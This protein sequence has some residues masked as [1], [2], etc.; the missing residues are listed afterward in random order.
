[1]RSWIAIITVIAILLFHS[2]GAAAS[3]IIIE[4]GAGD[5]AKVESAQSPSGFAFVGEYIDAPNLDIEYIS[6]D[7]N[8]QTVNFTFS[9]YGKFN[10]NVTY[11]M[12]GYYEN[13]QWQDLIDDLENEVGGYFDLPKSLHDYKISLYSGD[14]S[15]II[16]EGNSTYAQPPMDYYIS[17]SKFSVN[18]NLTS[19]NGTI[20]EEHFYGYAYQSS[21]TDFLYIQDSTVQG[22]DSFIKSITPSSLIVI[23]IGILGVFILSII[24]FKLRNKKVRFKGKLCP[25]CNSKID[26]S[27]DFCLKCGKD[28]D[29]VS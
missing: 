5:V 20:S 14:I 23:G 22:W 10:P 3:P 28:T 11:M 15:I 13:T 19:F 2:P 16:P 29:E 27:Q 8:D 6:F 4:D 18:I 7:V 1:M 17:D 26:D 21:S 24:I 12:V 25:Q 9:I